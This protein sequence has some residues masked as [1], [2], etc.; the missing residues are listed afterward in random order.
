MVELVKSANAKLSLA[1]MITQCHRRSDAMMELVKSANAKLSLAAMITQCHRRS[2]P[3]KK[4]KCCKY[5]SSIIP[6]NE[7]G[8]LG[9]EGL[10][11]SPH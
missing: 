4:M 9:L 2:K 11:T 5:S 1:A 10:S 3:K 6:H 7:G 8:D